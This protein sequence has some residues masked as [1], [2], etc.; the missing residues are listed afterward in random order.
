MDTLTKFTAHGLYTKYRRLLVYVITERQ[1]RYSE[2]G[3]SDALGGRI[4]FD[5]N[6]DVLDYR[7]ILRALH[8]KPPDTLD[9]VVRALER[10]LT[11]SQ[12]WSL[13]DGNTKPKKEEAFL[14]LIGIKFP[15][16][17]YIADILFDD[18]RRGLRRRGFGKVNLR[19]RVWSLM[20]QRGIQFSADWTC[21]ESQIVTFHDLSD[22]TLPISEIVDR[23]T[24]T[25]L[26]PDEY[27]GE[28]EDQERVFKSLLHN[29]LKQALY[30]KGIQWQHFTDVFIFC[31]TEEEQAKRQEAWGP[32]RTTRTVYE[33]TMNK[34]DPTKVLIHKHLAF[35]RQFLHLDDGWFLVI[36]PEWF[37][38]YDGYK[39][40]RFSDKNITWLKKHEWNKNVFT[41]LRFLV[42]FLTAVPTDDLFDGKPP[43]PYSFLQLGK[44]VSFAD[45]PALP[46]TKWLSDETAEKRKRIE[47]DQEEFKF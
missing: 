39:K 43:E 18:D 26:T 38:S 20:K 2:S 13:E 24:V 31:P 45:V 40:S 6:R 17:L 4:E 37:F 10:Q 29:C 41:H 34:K 1:E 36:K 35:S 15:S 30:K 28:D 19:D 22:S 5:I 46:D 27:Y 12:D 32:A 7:D 14:N 3:V 33:K 47:S 42:D 11:R 25:E 44:L 16:T 23:G 9:A 21:H 8:A